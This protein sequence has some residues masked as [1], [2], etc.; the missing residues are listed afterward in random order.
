MK[1]H[2]AECV[3][4]AH[5]YLAAHP[6]DNKYRITCKAYDEDL[7]KRLDPVPVTI[8]LADEEY[9]T[10]LSRKLSVSYNVTLTQFFITSL[11]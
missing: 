4:V 10:I 8:E 6:R 3:Q 11:K 9:I 2:L 7:E 5:E 1:K